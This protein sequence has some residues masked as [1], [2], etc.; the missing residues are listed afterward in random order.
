MRPQVDTARALT[1]RQPWAWAV[2]FGGKDVENRTWKPRKPFTLLVHAGT[3]W[4]EEGAEHLELLG[5]GIPEAAT[6]GGQIIGAVEVTGATDDS[7]SPWAIDGYWHWTL[8][9]PR[10]ADPPIP[11]RGRAAL[12]RPPAGWEDS[13]RPQPR[14][15]SA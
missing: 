6:W 2:I 1:L 13:F 10:P 5:I 8:E 3:A 9:N 7:D 14:R 4:S 15:R 12:F 11:T